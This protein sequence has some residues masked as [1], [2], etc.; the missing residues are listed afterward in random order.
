LVDSFSLRSSGLSNDA[1]IP[2]AYAAFQSQDLNP[3][4]TD[5]FDFCLNLGTVSFN[6]SWQ[7]AYVNFSGS[8]G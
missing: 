4:S 8:A 3:G 2:Y 1:Y 7:N 5:P 6:F